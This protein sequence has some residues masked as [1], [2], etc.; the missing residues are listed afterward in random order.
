M[1][2]EA[3][4]GA[5]SVSLRHV[6]WCFRTWTSLLCRH[7]P[8]VLPSGT[9][10]WISRLVPEEADQQRTSLVGVCPSFS[11]SSAKQLRPVV[12]QRFNSSS[13]VESVKVGR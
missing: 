7:C 12:H 5:V 3:R 6:D 10:S 1:L 8:V 2:R 4:G 13:T 9:A 11:R